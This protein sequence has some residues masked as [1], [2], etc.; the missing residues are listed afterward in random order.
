MANVLN[1]NQATI[2]FQILWYESKE[3]LVTALKFRSDRSEFFLWPHFQ[4]DRY[5]YN[6]LFDICI[7]RKILG[8]KILW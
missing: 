3:L 1:C 5:V 4:N 6:I 8:K 7:T 2:P